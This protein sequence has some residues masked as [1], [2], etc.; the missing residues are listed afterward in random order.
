[1][2]VR[3]REPFHWSERLVQVVVVVERRLEQDPARRYGWQFQNKSVTKVLSIYTRERDIPQ[4]TSARKIQQP[5][6]NTPSM[7]DMATG[8]YANVSAFHKILGTYRTG[9]GI[10]P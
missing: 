7:I 1:M 8:E 3:V 4:R 9:L 2:L 6:I 10:L 5:W